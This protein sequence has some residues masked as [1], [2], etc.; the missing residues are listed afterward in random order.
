MRL[1]D[2]K[3]KI[4]ITPVVSFLP[5][6]FIL[7]SKII[8]KK[9]PENGDIIVCEVND[10]HYPVEI[11]N[12]EGEIIE[13]FKGDII[14]GALG[15][16]ESS[17]NHSGVLPSI[18]DKDLY[19]LGRGGL[20]GK[21][22]EESHKDTEDVYRA[23]KLKL[24]GFLKNKDKFL[25]K[26]RLTK[27][28]QICSKK[29]VINTISKIPFILIGASSAEAGKTT[30]C[31][32]LI[33]LLSKNKKVIGIK[34]SSSGGYDD[35][36]KYISA[37]ALVGFN[38]IDGGLTETYSSTEK[39]FWGCMGTI[40]EKSLKSKPNVIVG[41]MG[42]DFVWTGNQYLLQDKDFAKRVKAIFIIVN[43]FLA[44]KGTLAFLKEWGILEDVE[45]KLFF[46]CSPFRNYF[47][48]LKRVEKYL[49]EFRNKFFEFKDLKSVEEIKNII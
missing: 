8:V 14:T 19:I 43:D 40:F 34:L 33:N 48:N 37:G 30:F 36:L 35:V 28:L 29:N 20:F 16:K 42:G 22:V 15:L 39:E 9:K 2:L 38:L 12:K 17:A 31:S 44:M 47:G 46:I 27:D 24:L 6:E 4:I 1:K 23:G 18:R 25:N 26:K 5:K 7:E 32:F 13:S 3:K 10:E 11:Q 21:L 49:P 41:E 45:R